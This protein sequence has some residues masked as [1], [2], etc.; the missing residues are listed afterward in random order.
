MDLTPRQREIAELVAE[1]LRVQEIADRLGLSR[2]T[3]RN[4]KQV[5]YSKLGARNAVELTRIL[6]E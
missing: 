3:I 2:H 1:G 6:H 5:I 4:H